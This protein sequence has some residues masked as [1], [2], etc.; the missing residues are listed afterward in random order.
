V[1]TKTESVFLEFF[2]TSR[3]SPPTRRVETDAFV[4]A[5]HARTHARTFASVAT[6]TSGAVV[7]GGPERERDTSRV[8]F[9]GGTFSLARESASREMAGSHSPNAS[10]TV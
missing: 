6:L 4:F 9:A 1:E 5:R 2:S 8:A 3:P 10:R 7:A